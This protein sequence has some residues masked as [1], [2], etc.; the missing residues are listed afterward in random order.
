M[1]SIR[2]NCWSSKIC[3]LRCFLNTYILLEQCFLFELQWTLK[4]HT[5]LSQQCFSWLSYLQAVK[6]TKKKGVDFL[7]MDFS[8]SFTP[9]LTLRAL[10]AHVSA[11]NFFPVKITT[12][13]LDV[14]NVSVFLHSC[15]FY[16]KFEWRFVED[17]IRKY[18]AQVNSVPLHALIR[19]ER[20]E[21]SCWLSPPEG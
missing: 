16:Y 17:T 12:N 7:I 2:S 15:F 19:P 18:I 5:R 6:N 8:L 1:F 21:E 3:C 9:L 10:S 20:A 14:A 4:V 13:C 11:R